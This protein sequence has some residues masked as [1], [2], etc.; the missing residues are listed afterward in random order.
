MLRITA[1]E[2]E[3]H[4]EQARELFAELMS[5]DATLMR[6]LGLDPRAA[7][8]FYYGRGEE[9]LPG[10]YAPPEGRLLLA[11]Y[12]EQW[13]GCAAFRRV[14]SDVCELKR[15]YVRAEFRGKQI[16]WRLADTVMQTARAAGYSAIRLET[17]TYLE[18]A[19]ALYSAIGFRVCEP[20]YSIPEA[21]RAFTIFMEIKLGD[22]GNGNERASKC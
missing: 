8:D 18:K 12:G 14:T 7:L 5:L 20:Y 4:Y 22:G 19:I 16:G 1:A 11:S 17:T 6:E 9:E 13:A 15:M 21:F 3:T 2:T 10:P